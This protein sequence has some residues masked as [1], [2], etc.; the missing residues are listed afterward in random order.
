MG[1]SSALARPLLRSR[2]KIRLPIRLRTIPPSCVAPP[3]NTWSIR[4]ASRLAGRAPRSRLGDLISR[5]CL[6]PDP[7]EDFPQQLNAGR[8]ELV[9]QARTAGQGFVGVKKV[10]ATDPFD[11]P[12][13][14]RTKGRRTPTVAAGGDRD[15]YK[16]AQEGGQCRARLPA[17]LPAGLAVLPQGT[18]GNPPRWHA[19]DAASI[20]PALR[21]AGLLV[22]RV[23]VVPGDAAAGQWIAAA[24]CPG[25]AVG[26]KLER[27]QRTGAPA[28]RLRVYGGSLRGAARSACAWFEAEGRSSRTGRRPPRE[29]TSL[30]SGAKVGRKFI[31]HRWGP[32]HRDCAAL[33]HVGEVLPSLLLL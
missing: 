22:V 12:N 25:E 1:E 32:N 17:A 23:G 29:G 21:A 18:R 7:V 4:A 24:G 16:K 13:N 6:K 2:R 31:L 11:A 9:T 27:P 15:A 3:S 20:P 19:V 26:G 30:R 10:L 33:Q 28:D 8:L 14:V 5:R